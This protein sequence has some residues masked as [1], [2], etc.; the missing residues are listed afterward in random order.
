MQTIALSEQAV[1]V[2][3]LRVKGLKLPV[4]EKRMGA[5]RELANAGIMTPVSDADGALEADYRFTEDGWARREELLLEAQDRV[6]RNRYDLPDASNLSEAARELLRR[7]LA[8]D[9]EVTDANR[10][11]YREL[12]TARIMIPMHTFIGGRE[13][14]FHFTY[15]GWK[16]R[17]EWIE[18]DCSTTGK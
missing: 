9:R 16:R 13:S 14:A 10:P 4:D 3:R 1:A 7:H 11:I 17:F 15:W 6:E 18:K 2:L 5:Y 8:G 12:A